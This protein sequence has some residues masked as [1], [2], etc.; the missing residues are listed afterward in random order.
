MQRLNDQFLEVLTDADGKLKV[1]PVGYEVA[2]HEEDGR[3]IDV[4]LDPYH[5]PVIS[6]RGVLQAALLKGGIAYDAET[7]T[8]E[9]GG[10]F[11][12]GLHMEMEDEG[13]DRRYWIAD[14]AGEEVLVSFWDPD[15]NTPHPQDGSLGGQ[16]R[17]YLPAPEEDAVTVKETAKAVID[18]GRIAIDAQLLYS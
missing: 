11:P 10:L 16:Y 14:T 3:L 12:K 8:F 4:S 13:G 15:A 5:E 6:V 2:R 17:D 18:A 1:V 9:E 7:E